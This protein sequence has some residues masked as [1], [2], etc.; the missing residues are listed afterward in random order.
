MPLAE[1]FAEDDQGRRF[2]DVMNDTRIS[3]IAILEFFDEPDRQRRMVEAE[4]D[5]D[6][7][8]L[9]GVVRE[10]EARPDVS[11]FFLVNGRH[12]TTRF[13]QA[14]GV[15]VKIVMRER[16]W[17]TTGRKGSLGVRSKATP[18][19]TGAEN[20]HNTGGLALWFTR[21]ERYDLATGTPY[22]SVAERAQRIDRLQQ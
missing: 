13:R 20:D 1:Q 8:A 14:V 9:A 4:R 11:Q 15:V 12:T 21:A 3:F 17:R 2:A 19:T 6:R 18:A 5:H 7:P 10:L 16:G 22:P